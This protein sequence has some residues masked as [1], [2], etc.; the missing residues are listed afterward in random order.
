MFADV[1]KT[2]CKENVRVSVRKAVNHTRKAQKVNVICL[3]F[4]GANYEDMFLE[5]ALRKNFENSLIKVGLKF[6]FCYFG[7]KYRFEIKNIEGLKECDDNLEN[8]M[9][10]L[11]I[12]DD[13]FYQ[14]KTTTKWQC[15]RYVANFNSIIF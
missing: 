3:N 15:Y 13:D 4:N 9:N 2:F 12:D 8:K 14:V 6:P 1:H 7:D 5:E 11:V 10:D